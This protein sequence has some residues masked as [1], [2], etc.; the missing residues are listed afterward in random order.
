LAFDEKFERVSNRECPC[1][2]TLQK[3]RNCRGDG[4][5]SEYINGV[6][7]GRCPVALLQAPAICQP[8]P[9]MIGNALFCR[10]AEKHYARYSERGL[11]PNPGGTGDQPA[12]LMRALDI[13]DNERA[14]IVNKMMKENRHA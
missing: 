7:V 5:S 2:A 10:E 13:L 6:A 9:E 4:K 1:S 12:K 14:R 8:T 3:L 11:L